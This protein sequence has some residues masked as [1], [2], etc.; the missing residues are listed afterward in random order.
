MQMKW[1]IVRLGKLNETK[2]PNKF[3]SSFF[4]TYENWQGDGGGG[5]GVEGGGG[6]G[7][8]K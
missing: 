3:V 7:T 1:M 8:N 2:N 4:I 6:G 5:R